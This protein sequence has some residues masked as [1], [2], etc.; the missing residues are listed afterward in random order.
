MENN[1]NKKLNNKKGY[2][3][4]FVIVIVSII[5]ALTAGLAN[6]T[7]KQSLLASIAKDSQSAFYS[8]DTAT[9]CGFFA[10]FDEEMKGKIADMKK[11]DIWSCGGQNLRY[12]KKGTGYIFHESDVGGSQP[13]F[14]I[15]NEKPDQYTTIIY[16]KGNS[17]CDKSNPR[18][19]ERVIKA[20]INVV[21]E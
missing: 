8:S 20:T 18:F 9:E 6:T 3:L 16:A 15:E 1:I 17:F 19:V 13:C 5:S 7:I 11:D 2:A 21:P 14:S 4:L 10:N 12:E